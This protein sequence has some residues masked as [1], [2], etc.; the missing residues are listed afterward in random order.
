[1]S[2]SAR[3]KHIFYA[4]MAK[5]L[6]AGFDIQ[7]AGN[8]LL[9]SNPPPSQVMLLRHL[10]D[11]LAAGQ[12]ITAALS[13]DPKA[14]SELERNIIGAGERGGMLAAAFQHLADYYAMLASSRREAT[15]SMIYPVIILHLGVIVS[16]VPSALMKGDVGIS[17]IFRNLVVA[18]LLVYVVLA[19]LIIIVYYIL[20]HAPV[21]RAVDEVVNRVPWIGKARRNLAMARFCKVY[22]AGIL[23]GISM[24]ETV[25]LAANAAQ[26]GVI[27]DAGTKLSAAA[28]SGDALGPHFIADPAFPKAFARSYS[29]GEQAGT[30]DDDLARWSQLFQ[31]EAQISMRHVS[32]MVPKLFY[33]LLVAF[34]AWKIVEFFSGY[35]SMLNDMME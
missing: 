1:M 11:G 35:Y 25:S 14:V 26:S 19:I 2:S 31:E 16:V 17:E 6:G 33:F 18:F 3:Q 27:R 28:K 24:V 32:V 29:T 5:L 12:S 15:S 10:N 30:L 9:D 8:V 7:R 4:E 20:K 13:K 23:A 22:H 21:N 34:I